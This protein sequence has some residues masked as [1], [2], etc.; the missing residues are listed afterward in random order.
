[1]EKLVMSELTIILPENRDLL[2]DRLAAEIQAQL[3]AH[4]RK[5]TSPYR[6]HVGIHIAE[7]RLRP[8]TD[9]DNYAKAINDAI[10][11]TKLLWRDDEQ[12][13]KLSIERTR[14]R[15]LAETTV[16]VRLS[17]SPAQHSGVPTWFRA[18]CFEAEAQRVPGGYA[19][20]AYKLACSLANEAPYDVED[21]AWTG[22]IERLCE[23]C[24]ADDREGIW[25]WFCA[26]LP[27]FMELVPSRRKARFVDGVIRAY[28]DER[29][30][31]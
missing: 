5:A 10:T 11:R 8:A 3:A 20:P 30:V 15:S 22:R 28:E 25:D 31:P 6:Y 23:T 4:G 13:D 7:G 14:R 1:M 29:I 27:K 21:D 24:G 9:V 12:V 2:I 17:K 19:T 18:S 26:H 16:T